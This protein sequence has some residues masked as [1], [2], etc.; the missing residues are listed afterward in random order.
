MNVVAVMPVRIRVLAIE[1]SVGFVE[2]VS[3]VR[4]TLDAVLRRGDVAGPQR[5]VFIRPAFVNQL[6]RDRVEIELTLTADLFRDDQA[7]TFEHR[8]V[9][10]G[11]YPADVEMSCEN[12]DVAAGVGVQDARTLCISFRGLPRTRRAGANLHGAT[13]RRL[14]SPA[15]SSGASEKV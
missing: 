3:V 8:Q 12:P 2:S 4:L 6:D 9:L 1:V 14:Q 5:A 10:H 7:G 13:G 15:P 11:G